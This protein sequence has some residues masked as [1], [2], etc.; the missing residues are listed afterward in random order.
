MNKLILLASLLFTFQVWSSTAIV[1]DLED[2]LTLSVLDE[3]FTGL[4]EFLNDSRHYAQEVHVLSHSVTLMRLKILRALEKKGIKVD[5]LTLRSVLNNQSE[6]A[7]KVNELKKLLE[8]TTHDLILIGD[9]G[10]ADAQAYATIAKAYPN[11][12]LA[13]YI[14]VLKGRALP[15]NVTPYFTAFDLALREYSAGRMSDAGVKNSLTVL[16]AEADLKKVF[17]LLAQCPLA[18]KTYLWQLATP[19]RRDALTLSKKLFSYCLTR[20]PGL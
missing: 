3:T 13:I 12:I 4:P 5:A 20:L 10:G 18:P 1:T 9:D 8:R 15:E 7:F 2:T 14:H 6:E 16:S 11:R 19:Y 17:P